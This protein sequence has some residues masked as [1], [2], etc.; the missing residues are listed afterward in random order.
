MIIVMMMRDV[1]A[2]S[3]GLISP[4]TGHCDSLCNIFR[5]TLS[6]HVFS[7]WIWPCPQSW[8]GP[9]K[10]IW[11]PIWI[12]LRIDATLPQPPHPEGVI[13]WDKEPPSLTTFRSKLILRW[14]VVSVTQGEEAG[15]RLSNGWQGNDA[16]PDHGSRP[17]F[18]WNAQHFNQTFEGLFLE[19][20]DIKMP[21]SC[22]DPAYMLDSDWNGTPVEVSRPWE[23]STPGL[24]W[25]LP[26]LQVRSQMVDWFT[27][28]TDNLLRVIRMKREGNPDVEPWM[29]QSIQF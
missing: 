19:S 11:N 10:H 26:L 9:E 7:P 15:S 27:V 8:R 13:Q 12:C 2:R 5:F 21:L 18:F 1:A 17:F 23:R 22:P 29:V 4:S 3:T 25:P 20:C 6:Y 28:L 24:L 16:I 14:K